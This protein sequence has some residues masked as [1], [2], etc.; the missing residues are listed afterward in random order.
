MMLL[1]EFL[2]MSLMVKMVILLQQ[3]LGSSTKTSWLE[4]M[5][6]VPDVL[7]ESEHE[8]EIQ[9]AWKGGMGGKGELYRHMADSRTNNPLG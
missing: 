8:L 6:T 1:L 4:L 2:T 5:M 9:L 7:L 3:M